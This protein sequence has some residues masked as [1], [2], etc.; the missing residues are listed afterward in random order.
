M[1]GLTPVSFDGL[2]VDSRLP[3]PERSYLQRNTP[4]QRAAWAVDKR[5]LAA[6]F[7]ASILEHSRGLR[8]VVPGSTDSVRAGYTVATRVVLIEIGGFWGPPER[9]TR[10][11][12]RG[13]DGRLLD[14]ISLRVAPNLGVIFPVTVKLRRMGERLGAALTDY[15]RLRTRAV[16]S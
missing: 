10:V 8:V 13:P 4:A 1:F 16:S 6:R 11:Q 12:I 3:I 14:E 2:M 5:E 7:Y 15:L 9:Q